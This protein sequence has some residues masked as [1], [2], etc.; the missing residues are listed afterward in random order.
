M[1][2]T[3]KGL[4][5]VWRDAIRDSDLDRTAKAVAF[6]LSTYVDGRGQ[7]FPSLETL[8]AGASVTARSVYPALARLEG[9]GFLYVQ[10][11]K[12]RRGNRYLVTLPETANE[13]RRSEWETAKGSARNTEPDVGNTERGSPESLESV[14]RRNA[15]AS[16]GAALPEDECLRCGK[17]RSLVAPDYRNCEDCFK[18]ERAEEAV[19]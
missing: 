11:S 9:N 7:A 4:S 8:A 18:V 14:R 6:V 19:A 10:R 2:S 3:R 1:S 17:R 5:A 12:T 13:L 15:A 16:D